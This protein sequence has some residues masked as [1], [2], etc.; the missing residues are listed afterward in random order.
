MTE[1]HESYLVRYWEADQCGNR[2][3]I[4]AAVIALKKYEEAAFK[5]GTI[6]ETDVVIASVLLSS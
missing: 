6:K 1:E 5:N 4:Y 2:D 3:E